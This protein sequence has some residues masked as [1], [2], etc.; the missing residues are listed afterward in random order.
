MRCGN[1]GTE[2]DVGRRFCDQCGAPFVAACP[3]CGAVNRPGARFCSDCGA[4]LED[5]GAIVAARPSATGPTSPAAGVRAPP[6]ERRLVSVL[7]ADLVGFTPFA[8]ERDPEDVRETLSRYFERAAEVIGRYGGS[9]EKF[10]GDAVMAVWGAPTA[11]EDDAERAVRAALELID[12]V[13]GLGGGIEGRVGVLTGE[14]AVTPGAVNQGLVAGDLVNTASRLQSVAPPGSVLVGETTYRAA[15]SAIA[16][17]AV[18]PQPLKG[19]ASPV[20]AYRAI[21]VVAGVGGRNRSE[22]LEAPFVGRDDELR[23][24]KDL[25]HATNRD[26]RPRLISI[27]GPAGI[28]KSRLA[29]EFSKY[30]DGLTDQIRWHAGRSPA[31]G[32]GITFWALG[33]MVR[34]RC[35]LLETDAEATT[36]AHVAETLATHIS[37]E[38]DRRWIEPALLE[39]LGVGGG[40]QASEQLF[41]AWRAF[42]ERLAASTPVVLAFEDFH[43]ADPGLID[44]VEQLLE[45]SRN[46]PITVLTLARPALLDR[47]PGWGAGTRNFISL[48]LEP[49][50]EAAMRELLAGLVPGLPESAVEA[51]VAR[52]EGIPLYAVETVRTLVAEGRL[53]ALD[54]GTYAPV[55]DLTSLSVPGTLTALIT[56]R[57]DALEPEQRAL[58]SDAA[59]LGQSFS[60]AG[61]AAVSGVPEPDLERRLRGLVRRELLSLET[62]PRSPERGQ[63]AFVQALIREVAY[64]TLAK[65]ERKARHLAAAR[66]FETLDSG[67]LAGALAGQYLAAYRYAAAGPEAEALATQA[68]IAL[69]AAAERA[70]SLGSHDQAVRFLEQALTVADEPA[71][72]AAIF[73]RAG[74]S[75]AAAGHYEIAERYFRRAIEA[76]RGSGD[77][78]RAARAAAALG[79]S[80]VMAFR[81]PDARS[82]LEQAAIDFAELGDDPVRLLLQSQLARAAFLD[83]D[84]R[85]SVAI[86]DG[87]LESAE[88]ANLVPLVAD[89]LV[90]RGSALAQFGRD[91]EGLGAIQTGLGLADTHDLAVVALRARN[92]LG[93]TLIERDPAAGLEVLRS[94]IADAVR[95]GRREGYVHAFTGAAGAAL[96]TGDWDWSLAELSDLAETDLEREDRAAVLGYI[97]IFRAFRGESVEAE[98][99]TLHRLIGEIGD[100][101]IVSHVHEVDARLAW[102]EGRLEV[103]RREFLEGA[104]LSGQ[105]APSRYPAAARVALWLRDADAAR[106]DLHELDGTGAHGPAIDLRRAAIEAGIDALEGR[107]AEARNGFRT[108][109]DRARDLRLAFDEA[110]LAIDMAILLEAGMPEVREAATRGREILARLGARPFLERLDAAAPLEQAVEPLAGMRLR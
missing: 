64:N 1:C 43:H 107:R 39:L 42:F 94:V 19:K 67:E 16:F 26:R 17:E 62:D 98:A 87:I 5:D 109:L 29:W 11:H 78:A 99:A 33:E 15:A 30:L 68:R 23:L 82:V 21:R 52:A 31:Y 60:L 71:D 96:D 48:H 108:A 53:Q 37:D 24:L 20:A 13:H 28:G 89:A 14:A 83:G 90:T 58:V 66:F 38:G 79:G 92:N 101:A 44:F 54:G 27:M 104:R 73:E 50:S 4:A 47:R 72:A 70:V 41:G 76:Y 18:G 51:I 69:G 36:R 93:A 55:G 91:Y 7:F 102:I 6:A 80:L 3:A 59:V 61:L 63:Y 9:V 35:G 10:I 106:A 34:A 32:D 46:L 40:G 97:V 81:V 56:S 75:A 103:A 85:R 49:L 2:H 86:I 25:F 22:T 74:E 65:T 105:Y 110:L 77:V 57:L 45:W 84:P 12:A 8:E 95:L 88:R 100:L